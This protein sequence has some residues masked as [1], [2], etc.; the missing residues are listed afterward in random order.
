[1]HALIRK[2]NGTQIGLAFVC[3]GFLAAP[4]VSQDHAHHHMMETPDMDETGRRLDP[5]AAQHDMSDEQLAALR[6]KI[7]LYRALTDTEARLNMALMGPNYEWY[8]SDLDMQGDIGVL[9]L[10]HG[11]GRRVDNR[12]IILLFWVRHRTAPGPGCGKSP[13]LFAI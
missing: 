2:L 1:M 6:E 4:A 13:L 3:S 11:V 5:N 7:A 12:L 9:V 8:V 10:A